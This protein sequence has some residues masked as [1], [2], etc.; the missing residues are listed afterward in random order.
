MDI[1]PRPPGACTQNGATVCAFFSRRPSDSG[2]AHQADKLPSSHPRSL[3]D[4][5]SEEV[6]G[7]LADEEDGSQNREGDEG[8]RS[9]LGEPAAARRSTDL[10]CSS[11]GQQQAPT[12][13]VPIVLH[14]ARH[15]SPRG[16]DRIR[17]ALPTRR[18]I[19][20]STRAADSALRSL[21]ARRRVRNNA[22]PPMLH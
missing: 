10:C 18:R 16:R 4:L 21:T 12:G 6:K 11:V 14:N 8:A 17:N 13:H 19:S 20:S 9:G 7:G 1:N 22:D 2:A 5:R 3:R 15:G